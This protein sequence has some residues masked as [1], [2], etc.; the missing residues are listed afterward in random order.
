MYSERTQKQQDMIRLVL[1][2]LRNLARI[3][4]ALPG[5]RQV[6]CCVHCMHV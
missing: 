2:L 4:A 6:R 3:D 5:D 1:L